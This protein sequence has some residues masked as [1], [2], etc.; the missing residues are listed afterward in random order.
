[1]QKLLRKLLPWR[2]NW[3]G[4]LLES[5]LFLAAYIIWVIFRSPQSPSRLFIGSLAVLVPGVAAV[6]LVF[7]FL[8]QLPSGTRPAWRFLGLG[9][10]CCSLGNLVRSIYEAAAGITVPLFSLA[11]V[12]GLLAYPLLLLALILYPFENRYA[13]SRFRFLLDVTISAGVVATLL[14]LMLGRPGPAFAQN[15]LKFFPVRTVEHAVLFNVG[16]DQRL[17]PAFVKEL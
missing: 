12:L 15:P 6:L 9:L 16:I 7:Q 5:V 8:P 14:G 10:A 13:P 1:M 17:N 11:D 4:F 3:Q 2:I